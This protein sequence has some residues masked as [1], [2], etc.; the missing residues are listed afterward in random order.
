MLRSLFRLISRRKPRVPEFDGR[1]PEVDPQGLRIQEL[2]R[3]FAEQGYPDSTKSVLR[4][5]NTRMD[6]AVR[7]AS[8]NTHAT[9]MQAHQEAVETETFLLAWT[10]R[11]RPQPPKEPERSL[12][13]RTYREILGFIAAM[14]LSFA[15]MPLPG[16]RQVEENAFYVSLGDGTRNKA[17]TRERKAVLRCSSRQPHGR[18]TA[19]VPVS[20]PSPPRTMP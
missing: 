2:L 16:E 9:L 13:Q 15:D 10:Q 8:N 6:D 19:H 14:H 5:V 18:E 17:P 3:R 4:F 7:V 11:Y 1:L 20:P 12:L